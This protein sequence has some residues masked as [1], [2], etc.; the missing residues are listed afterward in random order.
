MISD[1]NTSTSNG[2]KNNIPIS[3]DTQQSTIKNEAM[4]INTLL[5]SVKIS[6]KEPS[7]QVTIENIPDVI[8]DNY[9]PRVMRELLSTGSQKSTSGVLKES[10]QTNNNI[11]IPE[12]VLL[13]GN[14]VKNFFH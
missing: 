6:N 7:Q 10:A 14:I 5:T 9:D 8:L 13:A 3:K 2:E 1:N 12:D 11:T 4:T